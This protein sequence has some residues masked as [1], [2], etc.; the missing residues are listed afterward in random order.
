M[1]SPTDLKARILAATGREPSPTRAATRWRTAA[2]LGLG[3]LAMV[4][5]FI[6]IGGVRVTGRPI[7][8]VLATA[9][10]ALAFA[11]GALVMAFGRGRS[12]LGRRTSTLVWMMV[13]VPLLLFGWKLGAS[14]SCELDDWWPD[15][16]GLRCLLW[17]VLMGGAL[18]ASILYARRGTV[19][20]RPM[21]IGAASGVAVGAAAWVLT[22][23]WCPVG[24]AAHLAI[25]HVTPM[26]VLGAVGAL[27]GRWVLPVRRADARS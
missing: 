12:M 27:A 7:G 23:L 26:I 14:A 11:F 5:V 2:A 24:H 22:D 8:L 13:A 15:R 25:G 21:L 18:L 4:A 10:G 1:T 3:V 20:T 19:A 9:V 17:S 6:A 16:P